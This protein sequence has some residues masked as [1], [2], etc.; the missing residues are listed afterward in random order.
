M[1]IILLNIV[2]EILKLSS[3]FFIFLNFA[4]LSRWIYF[5]VFQFADLSSCFI[6][7]VEP[8]VDFSVQLY[9]L[10]GT[11]LYYLF[12]EVLT[13]FIH[14]SPVIDEHLYIIA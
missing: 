8:L 5:F 14:S 13:V 3:L 6:H 9:P 10:S 7:S 12:V 2:L 11:L 1:N 4:A